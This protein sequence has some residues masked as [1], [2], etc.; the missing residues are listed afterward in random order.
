MQAELYFAIPGDLENRTGGYAYDR[1]I[2]Q[3]FAAL[4]QHCTVLSLDASFPFPSTAAVADAEQIFS[5]L[6]PDS[7]VLVDGLAFGAMPAIVRKHCQRLR[8]IALC[9]HPLALETGLDAAQASAFKR[10]EKIALDGARAIIVTSPATAQTLVTQFAIDPVKISIAVPGSDPAPFARGGGTPPVL[11]TV[12]TLTKRKAHDVLIEALASLRELSWTARFAGGAH[13]DPQ[14]AD[15]LKKKVESAGL[16]DRIHFLGAIDDLSREYQ[17]ADLFVLA[18][19]YEG[20][21]MVYAEAIAYG[22]PVVATQCGAVSTLVPKTAGRIIPAANH[23]ALS[24]ALREL[25]EDS[26]LRAQ[27]QKGARKAAELLPRWQD[28]ARIIQQTI[29]RIAQ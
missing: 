7:I 18:S 23:A 22:L 29:D 11:L 12:A 21:G 17:Q 28:S 16:T 26:T 13:Y 4:G 27:L 1:R 20:Y 24:A 25:L 5:A 3:E 19:H 8:F 9:H 15:Y 14:W 2:L 6:S 10:S